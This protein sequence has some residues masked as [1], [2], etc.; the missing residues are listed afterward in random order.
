[1]IVNSHCEAFILLNFYDMIGN[2]HCDVYSLL[3]LYDM[4]GNA[5]PTIVVRFEW[6]VKNQQEA[7]RL[8]LKNRRSVASDIADILEW[9]RAADVKIC[10]VPSFGQV[11]SSRSIEQSMKAH[12]VC[13]THVILFN[14]SLSFYVF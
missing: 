1:M 5:H 4:I 11:V 12:Q 8:E 14:K 13:F 10:A 7:A 2:S 3:N 9:L 6:K